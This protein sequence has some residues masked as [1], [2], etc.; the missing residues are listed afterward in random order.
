[1]SHK[2]AV[3]LPA[4]SVNTVLREKEGKLLLDF[5]YLPIAAEH[6]ESGHPAPYL[7]LNKSNLT[8]CHIVNMELFAPSEDLTFDLITVAASFILD[9]GLVTPGDHL[10]LDVQFHEIPPYII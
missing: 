10:L 6:I 7:L 9:S 4:K 1:M 3:D 8:A 5:S 2:A